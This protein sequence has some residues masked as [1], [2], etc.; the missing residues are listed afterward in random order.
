MGPTWGGVGVG[1]NLVRFGR[2]RCMAAPRGSLLC[3]RARPSSGCASCLSTGRAA[4][5]EA[6]PRARSVADC[7]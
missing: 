2:F 3:P 6:A 5:R 1:G 7:P 4:R